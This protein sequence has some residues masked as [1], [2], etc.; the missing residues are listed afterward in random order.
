MLTKNIQEISAVPFHSSMCKERL[1]PQDKTKILISLILGCQIML[2]L[3]P[4]MPINVK[5][6]ETSCTSI[7]PLLYNSLTTMEMINRFS[8][9]KGSFEHQEIQCPR[10]GDGNAPLE[11]YQSRFQTTN[12]WQPIKLEMFPWKPQHIVK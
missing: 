11:V 6:I 2:L 9:A 12:K 3:Y 8:Q 10:F 1:K 4:V 7:F 5:H